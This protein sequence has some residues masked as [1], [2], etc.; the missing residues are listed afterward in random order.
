MMTYY[1]KIININ[2]IYCGRRNTI[3]MW[4]LVIYRNVERISAVIQM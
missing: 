2:N 4:K 1:R 3:S